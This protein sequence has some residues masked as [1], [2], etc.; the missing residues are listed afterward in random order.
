MVRTFARYRFF[1]GADADGRHLQNAQNWG[2]AEVAKD[3]I[4]DLGNLP[5][6]NQTPETSHRPRANGCN[7]IVGDI[8]GMPLAAIE[9]RFSG[10]T[11]INWNV[12]IIKVANTDTTYQGMAIDG[13]GQGTVTESASSGDRLVM[14][15]CQIS[16][17][18]YDPDSAGGGQPGTYSYT[19]QYAADPPTVTSVDP[20]QILQGS[21]GVAVS[22]YGS[23]FMDGPGLSVQ[24]SG[25]GVAV[26]QPVFVSETELR[27][28]MNVEAAAALGPRDVV[29]TNPDGQ[30]AVGQGILTI[31]D[32]ITQQDAGVGDGGAGSDAGYPSSGPRGGCNCKVASPN[33]SSVWVLLFLLVFGFWLRRRS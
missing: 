23:N 2:G 6:L 10:S 32:E 9:F 33:S 13:Q 22:V 14:V 16:G 26:T 30:S 28:Q 17:T 12:D 18:G 3:T 5:L 24:V 1:V 20:N 8:N 31:V 7:Y 25:A 21:L 11:N 29:V 27:V 4:W 15:V 19:I